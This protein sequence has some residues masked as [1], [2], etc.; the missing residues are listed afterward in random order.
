MDAIIVGRRTAEFDDPL[1]TARLETGTAPARVATRVVVDSSAALS[2]R[3]QLVQ[4]ARQVP[5]VVAAASSASSN[6]V[7]QLRAAGAEV[8]IL[9]GE[10]H[11][12]R[13]LALLDELGRR[14]LTNVLVEGGSQLLGS[15]FDVRQVDEV[16]CFIAPKIFGGTSAAGPVGGTGVAAPDLA[17]VL[18]RLTPR[19]TGEDLYLQG[20]IR[21]DNA[22][23][24]PKLQ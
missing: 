23:E 10:T 17:A 5:F 2:L 6:N 13:L 21:S 22:G 16:H 1:L 9:P 8:L 18:S 15:L 7:E 11:Q 19:T 24:A 4:T 12:D 3:N 20:R 14:R